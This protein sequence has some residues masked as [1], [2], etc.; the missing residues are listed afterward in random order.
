[1]SAAAAFLQHAAGVPAGLASS[2][3]ARGAN[4]KEAAAMRMRA[5]VFIM[6]GEVMN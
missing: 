5:N 2:A 1:L 4:A 6:V 3:W